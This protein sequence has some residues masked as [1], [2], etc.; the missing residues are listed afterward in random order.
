MSPTW[1]NTTMEN[2][3]DTAENVVETMDASRAE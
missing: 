1:A 2:V 3:M